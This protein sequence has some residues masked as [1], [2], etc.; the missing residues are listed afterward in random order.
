MYTYTATHAQMEKGRLLKATL[1]ASTQTSQ[2][3]S[4]PTLQMTRYSQDWELLAS[5]KA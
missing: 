4:L 5:Y 2:D 3:G 1:A